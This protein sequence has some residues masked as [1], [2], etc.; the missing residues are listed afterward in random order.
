MTLL[1]F[2]LTEVPGGKT[3]LLVE[4]DSIV[5]GGVD[6]RVCERE[7]Q[8]DREWEKKRDRS[9]SVYWEKLMF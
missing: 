4:A 8:R 1:K 3:Q 5:Q 7:R 2:V 6:R 9:F